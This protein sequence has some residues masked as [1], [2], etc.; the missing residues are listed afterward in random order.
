MT[1]TNWK[2]GKNN[3]VLLPAQMQLPKNHQKQEESNQPPC[4]LPP[5]QPSPGPPPGTMVWHSWV[6]LDVECAST[7]SVPRQTAC[8]AS[9]DGTWNLSQP[10]SRH[11]LRPWSDPSLN[12]PVQCGIL[13]AV[14]TSP[15]SRRSGEGQLILSWTDTGIPRVLEIGLISWMAGW[16]CSSVGRAPYW[17]AADAGAIQGAAGEFSPRVNFQFRLSYGVRT[18]PC[19]IAC[20]NTCVHVKDSVVHARV[21]WNMETLK[22]PAC[23]IGWVAWFCHS[24]LSWGKATWI[25]HRRNPIGTIQL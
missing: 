10:R 8:L 19:T 9:W 13:T 21:Q 4:C 5:A 11:S 1:S 23:T 18:P 17:H 22:H 6:T 15:T 2:N 14:R 3:G 16:G 25:S 7:I 20:I 24:W 12:M